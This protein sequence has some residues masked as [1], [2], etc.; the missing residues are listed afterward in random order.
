M[1]H[2]ENILEMKVANKRMKSKPDFG[3]PKLP[4]KKYPAQRIQDQKRPYHPGLLFSIPHPSQR[5]HTHPP[6][7]GKVRVGDRKPPSPAG[8]KFEDGSVQPG[9]D[10]PKRPKAKVR[11]KKSLSSRPVQR[12]VL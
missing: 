11:K 5:Y 8:T 1:P 10:M 3:I 6:P 7:P 2:A 12:T 9:P 4:K